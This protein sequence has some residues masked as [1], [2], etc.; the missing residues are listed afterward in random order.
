[1]SAEMVEF[2]GWEKVLRETVPTGLQAAY[3]E[4]VVKFRSWLRERGKDATAGAFKEHLAWKKSYLPPARYEE[5]RQALRWYWEKGK[6]SRIQNSG[7][8]IQNY[9][10]ICRQQA[11]AF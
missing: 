5:R 11:S 10:R 4:A 3:Q 1:M 6:K 7:V 8:G 9:L 2:E